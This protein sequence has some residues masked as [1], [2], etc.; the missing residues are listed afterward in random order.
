VVDTLFVRDEQN[1]NEQSLNIYLIRT[2]KKDRQ[3][4]STKNNLRLFKISTSSVMTEIRIKATVSPRESF[5]PGVLES[6]S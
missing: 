4:L 3:R 5:N 2:R 6:K 1:E